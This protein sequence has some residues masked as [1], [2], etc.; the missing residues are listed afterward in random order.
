LLLE[1][2]LLLIVCCAIKSCTKRNLFEWENSWYVLIFM[3]KYLK[4]AGKNLEIPVALRKGHD[5]SVWHLIKV[6]QN[7]FQNPVWSYFKRRRIYR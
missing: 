5:L 2:I 3:K 4:Q 7:F 1:E 6:E